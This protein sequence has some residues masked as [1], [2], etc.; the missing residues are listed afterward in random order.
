LNYICDNLRIYFTLPD[1][2][3]ENK[4]KT[5]SKNCFSLSFLPFEI[6]INFKKSGCI[7]AIN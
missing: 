4:L 5:I 1:N 6:S 3:N 7:N 2:N